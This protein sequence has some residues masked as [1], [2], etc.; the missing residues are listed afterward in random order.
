MLIDLNK[1]NQS[2]LTGERLS[3]EQRLENYD[4]TGMNIQTVFDGLSETW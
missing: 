3:N 1:K 2:S 4:V